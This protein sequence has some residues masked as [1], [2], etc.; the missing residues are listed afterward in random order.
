M[1]RVRVSNLG[2]ALQGG[3]SFLKLYFLP[4]RF[5]VFANVVNASGD[6][7]Q[8]H[9]DHPKLKSRHSVDILR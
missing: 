1:I 7:D 8:K 4:Y 9:E 5:N 3:F 2:A 6:E